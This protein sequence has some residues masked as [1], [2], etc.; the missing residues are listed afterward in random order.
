IK[1]N[2]LTRTPQNHSE[3]TYAPMI[4]RE[5]SYIDF[6]QPAQNV[7]GLIKGL[8]PF[9]GAK[10]TVKGKIV[11]VFMAKVAENTDKQAGTIIR[12]ESER[13]VVAAG[14]GVIALTSVQ[15]EGKKRM[16]A[17]DFARG[18]QITVGEILG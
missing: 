13:L 7:C 16:A 10:I 1:D 11:K 2:T 8:S 17:G 14:T 12:V 15:P 18:Y 3:M 4:D 5:L 6:N 9:P